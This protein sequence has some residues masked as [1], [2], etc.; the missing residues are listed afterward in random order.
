MRRFLKIQESCEYMVWRFQEN[1]ILEYPEYISESTNEEYKKAIECAKTFDWEDISVKS[2]WPRL[3][4]C[5]KTGLIAQKNSKNSP[6]M[7]IDNDQKRNFSLQNK[8]YNAK[9]K[10][11]LLL[12]T[13]DELIIKDIIK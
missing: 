10:T 9:Q 2:G 7:Y 11:E 6:V 1:P 4:K 5:R 3:F 8:Y 13:A 12:L